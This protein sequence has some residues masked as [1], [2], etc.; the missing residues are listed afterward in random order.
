MSRANVDDGLGDVVPSVELSSL[1]SALL[2]ALR[3]VIVLA[4]IAVWVYF[5]L[6]VA[7]VSYR[8]GDLVGAVFTGATFGLGFLLVGAWRLWNLVW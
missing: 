6:Q 3:E 2:V 8:A 1:R 5:W 7:L 4:A